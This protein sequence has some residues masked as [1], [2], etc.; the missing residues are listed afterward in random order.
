MKRIGPRALLLLAFI[1][2]FALILKLWGLT[3]ES[4][5]AAENLRVEKPS[6]TRIKSGAA[7]TLD[8]YG[9]G[10]DSDLI[11]TLVKNETEM[12]DL[13]VTYPVEGV[14]NDSLIVN[15]VLYLGS[16]HKGLIAID[17]KD[18]LSPRWISEYWNGKSIA[19]IQEKDGFLYLACGKSGVIVMKILESGELEPII[20]APINEVAIGIGFIGDKVAVASGQNG[21]VIYDIDAASQL[22]QVNQIDVG[23]SVIALESRENFLY[24][25]TQ[26]KTIEVYAFNDMEI[27]HQSSISLDHS[28]KGL[29]L[30]NDVLY[31]VT[32]GMLIQFDME[33]PSHPVRSGSI[34]SFGSADKI[35]RGKNHLYIIDDFKRLT[36][37]DPIA[38]QIMKVIDLPSEIRTV[39]EFDHYLMVGGLNSGLNVVDLTSTAQKNSQATMQ[40]PG[41][42]RDILI[43][44]EWLYVADTQSG[45][46][47]KKL[48]DGNDPFRQ[49][50]R[51]R[52]ESFCLD[53]ARHLLF[54]ALGD[55]GIEVFDVRN[56]GQPRSVAFWQD[57]KALKIAISETDL[58]VT[59]GVSGIELIESRDLSL[60]IV[61]K[62]YPDLHV[63][64][65]DV[66]DK[67]LFLASKKQGL[68]IYSIKQN[69]LDF[70]SE[71]TT[72]YPMDQFAYTVAVTVVDD[73]AYVANGESGLMIVD[74]KYPEKTKIIDLIDI[75]GFVKRV[76]VLDGKAFVSSQSG[77][78]TVVNVKQKQ[79]SRLE[80]QILF[81]RLTRGLLVE[82]DYIY[83]TQRDTGISKIPVPTRAHRIEKVS[84]K[85]VQ[86]TFPEIKLAGSYNLQ[87]RDRI[88]SYVYKDVVVVED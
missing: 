17:V 71:T 13:S 3:V 72:P 2:L 39:A 81:K 87:V 77:G 62:L 8:L 20:F 38:M 79:Q 85:N 49:I 50:S 84:A 14:F 57:I 67:T 18:P 63:L 65:M 66:V 30:Y 4:F 12:S 24:L 31:A 23:S 1:F 25:A 51:R 83:V 42:S 74:V 58:I 19:D 88:N 21:A 26:N 28:L 10:F 40:T 55:S 64:D 59:K 46:Q 75:P 5:D 68:R 41:H 60:P 48:Q 69:E 36:V 78:V 86:V 82:D 47:I 52:A 70:L 27:E 73:I 43:I 11:V 6:T 33:V 37:V 35:I 44:D 61:K 7:I 9:Q 53:R 22:V 76:R 32:A 45:V 29:S 54:V 56:P 34:D 16:T 80:S 15:N